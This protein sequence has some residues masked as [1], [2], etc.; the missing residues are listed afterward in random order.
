MK[1]LIVTKHID[2]V[3]GDFKAVDDL[4]L[5]LES[6]KIYGIIGPN[7][8]GKSTTMSLLMGLIF[9]S[10]GQGSIK[11]YPLGSSKAKALIG[12]APEFPDFYHNMTCLE[13]LVYMGQLSNLSY[14]QSI[15]RSLVLLQEFGLLEYQDKK[16]VKFSTGMK[17]KVALIQGLLHEPEILLLDEPTANLDPTSRHEIIKLIKNLVSQKQMTVLIS[18]HVLTELETIIDHVIMINHGHVLINEPLAVVLK[19]FNQT[20]IL[21][22]CLN[23]TALQT[24]LKQ[25]DYQFTIDHDIF[26]ITTANKT[27]C[28]KQIIKFIYEND[29]ELFLLKE[30]QI[31]LDGLYQQFMEEK[32]E[33]LS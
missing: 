8:A 6:G 27:K 21:V 22:S 25:N 14:M 17:K 19:Q 16:V 33:G 29:D 10:K 32:N 11:G 2:K 5:S 15:E 30:D 20:S 1:D 28:K 7:G 23:Q 9:P 31:T 18:S 24:F 4:S 26:R 3:F 13:Y 12:Y